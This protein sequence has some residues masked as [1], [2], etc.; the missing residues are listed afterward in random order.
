[1]QNK[2]TEIN[3]TPLFLIGV[4]R[5]GTTL[6]CR[7][8][9]S[10]PAILVTNE[11]GVCSQLHNL[12]LKSAQG[13]V[14]GTSFGKEYYELWSNQLDTAAPQLIRDYSTHS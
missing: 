14:A 8:L 2:I 4:P 5:S 10:H 13:R 12:I 9:N 3:Q 6:L 11:T 1:M 7:M